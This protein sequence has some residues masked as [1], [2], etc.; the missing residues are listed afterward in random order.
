MLPSCKTG[1]FVLGQQ[2]PLLSELSVDGVVSAASYP[3]YLTP[4]HRGGV[5]GERSF[6]TIFIERPPLQLQVLKLEEM[7]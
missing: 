6:V 7:F 1:L 2:Q 5:L 4:G 3:S